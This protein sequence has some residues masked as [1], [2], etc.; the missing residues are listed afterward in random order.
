[1]TEFTVREKSVFQVGPKESLNTTNREEPQFK[2]NS[3][4]ARFSSTDTPWKT[5]LAW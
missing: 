2:N 1:M 5:L 4:L 3:R